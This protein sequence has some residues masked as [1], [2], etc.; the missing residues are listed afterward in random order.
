MALA[1]VFV[2]VSDAF[3]KIEILILDN[4]CHYLHIL[5]IIII[6]LQLFHFYVKNFHLPTF[7]ALFTHIRTWMAKGGKRGYSINPSRIENFRKTL[8]LGKFCHILGASC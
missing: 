6:L 4:N 3:F 1:I 7:L 8:Y 2:I 5:D